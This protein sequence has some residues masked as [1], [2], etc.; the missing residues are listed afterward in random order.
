V[1]TVTLLMHSARLVIVY[2]GATDFD[3]Y[4]FRVG[5]RGGVADPI[6][7]GYSDEV[8]VRTCFLPAG[9]LAMS[10]DRLAGTLAD[11]IHP[12]SV[13]VLC[14]SGELLPAA[15][16]NGPVFGHAFTS[17]VRQRRQMTT[18]D[19]ITGLA[20]GL[21]S[22]TGEPWSGTLVVISDY[23][24]WI[25]TELTTRSCVIDPALALRLVLCGGRSKLSGSDATLRTLTRLST[26]IPSRMRS[27]GARPLDASE[28]FALVVAASCETVT[29]AWPGLP[30]CTIF[31]PSTRAQAVTRSYMGDRVSDWSEVVAPADPS[32]Q[33]AVTAVRHAF[34]DDSVLPEFDAGSQVSRI[35]ATAVRLLA[36]GDSTAFTALWSACSANEQEALLSWPLSDARL[37]H[38][39]RC[40]TAA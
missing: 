1:V 30:K 4:S 24:D 8:G 38:S 22:A 25:A 26:T 34:P 18:V 10:H 29:L 32:S 20:T 35:F 21:P 7:G 16:P 28:A 11:Q 37:G 40:S 17:P 27:K 39:L 23:A 19:L 6:N 15:G 31:A 13:I 33:A 9:S 3:D 2:A 36:H 14:G 12:Q 5:R